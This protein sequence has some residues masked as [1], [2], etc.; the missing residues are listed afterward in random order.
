MIIILPR[1]D[2]GRRQIL[3][4]ELGLDG[5]GDQA[6][7]RRLA[8]LE[9]I[10]TRQGGGDF[11][12]LGQRIR[13]RP[14]VRRHRWI[15]DLYARH[16]L[17]YNAGPRGNVDAEAAL[18]TANGGHN[19]GHDFGNDQAPELAGAECFVEKQP[20]LDGPEAESDE[21]FGQALIGAVL[22]QLP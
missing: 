8:S 3:P 4:G 2:D 20:A 22:R 1:I 13:Q 18:G 17:D 21:G 11:R 6:G 16:F 7:H 12:S 19:L 14:R 15:Q 9:E 10:D 5:A